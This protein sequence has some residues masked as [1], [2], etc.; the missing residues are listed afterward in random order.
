M[1]ELTN[2]RKEYSHFELSCSMNIKP[3]TVTGLIGP[4]GAGKTTLLKSILGLAHIDGG[5]IIIFGKDIHTIDNSDRNRIG[6]VL[7]DAGF[8]D[9]LSIA[10]IIR[11]SSRLYTTFDE[12]WMRKKC[13]EFDLDESKAIRELST[14]M[15]AKLYIL[16][17]LSHYAS[18]LILDEP[19]AGL[20]VIARND[21]LTLIREYMEH[22][23][24]RSVLISSHVSSDIE[25]LCDDIIMINEG[26]IILHEDTDVLLD[27]YAVLRLSPSEYE[28]LDKHYILRVTKEPYGYQCLTDQKQFYY[29]NYPGI[30]IERGG[31]D[32]LIQM[33]IRGDSI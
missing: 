16:C 32:S 14:G 27:N 22:E 6:V 23:P 10:D 13:K 15:R 4:N 21:I 7:S 12:A 5:S 11:I 20:D 33:M 26:R 28:Q 19:T 8:S 17:A 9:H 24:E 3:G 29:E 1:I 18:L 30:A 31:I 2:L 25:S